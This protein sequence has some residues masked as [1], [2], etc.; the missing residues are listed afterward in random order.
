MTAHLDPHK[1][2]HLWSQY[3][4]GDLES[5][6]RQ[7]LEAHLRECEVCRREV[8]LLRQTV[9]WLSQLGQSQEIQAPADFVPKV[10]HRLR[11]KKRHKR[12]HNQSTTKYGQT[13]TS[14]LIFATLILIT[15]ILFYTLQI[16]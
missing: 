13:L 12:E 16:L 7:S 4:E 3:L 6:E 1:Q 15:F 14:A 2:D 11:H 8:K 10:R 5:A 9:N